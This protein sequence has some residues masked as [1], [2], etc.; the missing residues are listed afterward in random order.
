MDRRVDGSLCSPENGFLG[1]NMERKTGMRKYE[2]IVFDLDGTLLDTLEDLKDSVNY[3]LGKAG[4]PERSLDEVR[5][6]VGNGAR[7]LMELVIPGGEENPAFDKVSA[8][9][10]EHYAQHCNDK[11]KPYA[12]VPELLAELSRKGY[13][14]AIVSNKFYGAVQELKKLYFH[15][16][17]EVAIGEKEGIRK[18]PAPDTVIEALRELGSSKENAVYVGDSEVD[19]ATAANTGMDCISVTWGF[20]TKDEQKRVGGK[21]FADDPLDILKLV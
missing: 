19:I 11:T 4:M 2:T 7:R 17:I 13:K 1:T 10:K 18:K 16:Y 9:Y 3:A 15:E 14:M 20:R 6:S 8:D 21:V 12:H 5:R